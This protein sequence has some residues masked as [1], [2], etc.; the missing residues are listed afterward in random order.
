MLNVFITCARVRVPP[1][2]A[3]NVHAGR[4]GAAAL[5]YLG[6]SARRRTFLSRS[7][8]ASHP[9]DKCAG[10]MKKGWTSKGGGGPHRFQCKNVNGQSC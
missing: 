5:V 10:N 6:L 8:A 1:S 7:A 4:G 9:G 3:A 2:S